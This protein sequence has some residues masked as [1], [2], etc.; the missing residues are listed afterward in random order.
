MNS[1]NFMKKNNKL[2]IVTFVIGL[3]GCTNETL[4]EN[5]LVQEIKTKNVY[6]TA[7]VNEYITKRI[8]GDKYEVESLIPYNMSSHDYEITLKQ[9][10]ELE[11]AEALIYVG[12]G[13]ESFVDKTINALDNDIDTVCVTD[14]YEL[15][16]N[17]YG[18]IHDD[19]EDN[20]ENHEEDHEESRYDPHIWITPNGGAHIA[21]EI[22]EYFIQA[23]EENEQFYTENYNKLMSELGEL[24]DLYEEVSKEI[25][26]K[27]FYVSHASYTYY[28]MYN[29]LEQ[30]P[31]EGKAYGSEPELSYM[32]EI[33]DDI[34]DNGINTI[35]H[36]S[37]E[38]SKATDMLAEDLGVNVL[39]LSAI[40][41]I[42]EEQI[43]T[44]ET[45]LTLLEKNIRTLQQGN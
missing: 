28:N 44:G 34:I 11:E 33:H 3:T 7:Y 17:T 32:Q 20:E 12:A 21:T 5:N 26:N 6:T 35:Y 15:M 9:M 4:K 40:E 41:A 8:V 38:N 19:E 22:Y 14:G 42:T 27:K 23:D 24:N 29:G 2:F 43:N 10:Q 36:S 16:E 1:L 37:G 30:I 25:Q 45:Y 39:E 18:H 13:Y 31:I